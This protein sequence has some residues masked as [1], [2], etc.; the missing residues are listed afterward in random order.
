MSTIIDKIEQINNIKRQIKKAINSRGGS[1]GDDFT[2]Y[3]KAILDALAPDIDPDKSPDYVYKEHLRIRS[4]NFTCFYALFQDDFQFL[5]P[6]KEMIMAIEELDT[7]RADNFT[8]LFNCCCE[9]KQLELMWWNTSNVESMAYTFSACMNLELLDLTGWDTS[10]CT[11]MRQMFES[12]TNLKTLYIPSF[13]TV[14]VTDMQDMFG[15]CKSLVILNL[16][17]F[18]TSNVIE[19]SSMFSGCESL[20]E[21]KGELDL[22]SC[23]SGLNS[24]TPYGSTFK[25]CNNLKTVHLKNIYKYCTMSDNA[26]WSIDLS[27]TKLTNKCLREII[28]ELPNLAD[29]GIKNNK[30]IYLYLHEYHTLTA[31]DMQKAYD[32]GWRVTEKTNT[33]Y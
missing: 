32:K 22:S 17:S 27:Y 30:N 19:M 11:N 31:D 16:S 18:N 24:S 28:D 6:P 2:A 13:N 25:N 4:N 12:C 5:E 33:T 14:N 10:K 20:T 9:V 1:V 15:G 29:K 7:S 3:P 8:S 23:K 26:K 21:I